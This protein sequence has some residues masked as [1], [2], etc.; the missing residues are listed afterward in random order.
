MKRE[1]IQTALTV[2]QGEKGD[3]RKWLG[4]KLFKAYQGFGGQEKTKDMTK[5]LL[6]TAIE[7]MLEIEDV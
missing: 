6:I 4:P 3:W 5:P 2:K 7:A 1:L